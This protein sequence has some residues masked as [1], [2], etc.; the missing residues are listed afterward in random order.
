MQ[1][2]TPQNSTHLLPT[3]WENLKTWSTRI[4][5]IL[6]LA[7][8]L[9]GVWNGFVDFL[10]LRVSQSINSDIQSIK[11]TVR[12]I[13]DTNIPFLTNTSNAI[14]NDV[15]RQNIDNEKKFNTI[16]DKLDKVATKEDLQLILNALKK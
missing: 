5:L 2:K 4:G 16:N 12:T 6:G 11:D 9:A 13:T 14:S 10:A 15:A 8:T 1:K 3:F 7:A